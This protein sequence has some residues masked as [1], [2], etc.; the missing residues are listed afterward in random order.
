MTFLTNGDKIAK[1]RSAKLL[2]RSL[3]VGA[4]CFAVE[5]PVGN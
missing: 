2:L 3:C 1:L 5:T 4:G